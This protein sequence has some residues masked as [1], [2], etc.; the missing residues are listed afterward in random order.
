MKPPS[1]LVSKRYCHMQMDY[2]NSRW[3][4]RPE[5]MSNEITRTLQGFFSLSRQ[6]HSPYLLCHQFQE[7]IHANEPGKFCRGFRTPNLSAV[8]QCD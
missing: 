3:K 8:L 1:I 2:V 6:R 7:D 5:S 4:F